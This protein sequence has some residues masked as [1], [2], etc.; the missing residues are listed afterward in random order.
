MRRRYAGVAALVAALSIGLVGAPSASADASTAVVSGTVT[1]QQSGLPVAGVDVTFQKTDETAVRVAA[2]TDASGIYT[3]DVPAG[4]YR[5]SFAKLGGG[6]DAYWTSYYPGTYD[7]YA[8]SLIAVVAGTDKTGVDI[9]VPKAGGISGRVTLGGKP[10]KAASIELWNDVAHLPA[11]KVTNGTYSAFPLPV[12]SYRVRLV[13]DQNDAFLTTF[14][15]NTVREP[16]AKV[17]TVDPGERVT[18]ANIAAKAGATV[19]G[20]VTD[21]RGKPLKGRAVRAQNLTRYGS[22]EAVTDA[23]GA[24]VI[25]GLASGKVQVAIYSTRHWNTAIAS[26]TVQAVQGKTLAAKTL[27]QRAPSSITGTIAVK[28]GSIRYL[29]VSLLDSKKALVDTHSPRANGAITFTDLP[30]GRYTVVINGANTAAK[31]TVKSGQK[32]SFGK[33][34]RGKQ[35][36]L[37][38]VVRNPDG[39]LASSGRV[40]LVDAYGRAAGEAHVTAKGTYSILGLVRGKY[41]VRADRFGLSDDV[42]FAGTT[43]LAV[44]A[45]HGATTSIKVKLSGT[46]TGVVKNAKGKPVPGIEVYSAPG[47]YDD[48]DEWGSDRTDSSGK[49]VVKGLPA[50]T[51]RVWFHDNYVGGYL[52]ATKTATVVAGKTTKVS[53]LTLR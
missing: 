46:L 31:V 40:S 34:T 20:K 48:N 35:S 11:V 15:G 7:R 13:A 16:D 39:T 8:A 12:G 51:R 10:I 41:T 29:S 1:D 44:K 50:G 52:T 24:Y 2:T 47:F 49:Y 18:N 30:A 38:G 53:T 32:V 3:V 26:T 21:S 22:G 27:V 14:L 43:T 25:R 6:A 45:G 4:S 42:H 36:T 5:A 9:A 37:K 33:L 23:K 19:K 17:T 28:S